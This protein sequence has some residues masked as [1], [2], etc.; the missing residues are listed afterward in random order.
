[1]DKT[2]N[3]Q[4]RYNDTKGQRLAILHR[5]AS[6]PATVDQLSTD[7]NAPDPRKRVSELRRHGHPIKTDKTVRTNPDGSVNRVGLYVLSVTDTRQ[8]EL[9]FNP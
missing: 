8:C 7:C 5:L 6:G 1:M 3:T 2:T 9:N 4:P